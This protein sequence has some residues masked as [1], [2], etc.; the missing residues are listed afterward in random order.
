MA[1]ELGPATPTFA[2]APKLPQ[3]SVETVYVASA[4][5]SSP[6]AAL[7]PEPVSVAPLNDAGEVELDALERLI[8]P[9]TRI[10][11]VAHLSNA[12][13]TI[14]PIRRICEVAHARGVPVLVDGAQAAIGG[15]EALLK[16]EIS[17]QSLQEY[18]GAA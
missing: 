11:S 12:L 2:K 3:V 18:H 17:V 6:A 16:G 14:L 5:S 15:I 4:R 9:R 13:G 10:V 7:I 8:T 1:G